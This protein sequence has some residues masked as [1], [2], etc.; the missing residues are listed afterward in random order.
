MGKRGK[1][2]VCCLDCNCLVTHLEPD[3]LQH[4][5]RVVF[6][7]PIIQ[8]GKFAGKPKTT[9]RHLKAALNEI[10]ICQLYRICYL[11]TAKKALNSLE[12]FTSE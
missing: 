9:S 1:F 5:A 10:I 7:Q 6:F 8:L 4:D 2:R 3:W 12:R 11:S